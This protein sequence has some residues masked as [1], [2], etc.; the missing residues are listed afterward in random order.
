MVT[1]S[2]K[3]NVLS[4]N[5]GSKTLSLIKLPVSFHKIL[6]VFLFSFKE[7][8]WCPVKVKSCIEFCMLDIVQHRLNH[9]F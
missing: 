6:A 7:Y 9:G 8:R 4:P 1:F 5:L 2:L 3:G